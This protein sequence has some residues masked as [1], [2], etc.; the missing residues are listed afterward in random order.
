MMMTMHIAVV[1]T[2]GV[3][4]SWNED[5]NGDDDSMPRVTFAIPNRSRAVVV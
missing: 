4:P 1:V 5:V 3:V 2:V